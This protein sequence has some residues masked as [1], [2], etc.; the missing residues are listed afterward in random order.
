MV[1]TILAFTWICFE[2][3]APEPAP[4]PGPPVIV[5]EQDQTQSVPAEVKRFMRLIPAKPGHRMVR[6][7][8]V[9][10]F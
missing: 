1:C 3:P 7:P 9:V 2:G 8:S 6:E 5:A 10:S 4:R